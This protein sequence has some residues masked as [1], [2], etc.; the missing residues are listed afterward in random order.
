MPPELNLPEEMWIP[1]RLTLEVLSLFEFDI[2]GST[3]PYSPKNACGRVNDVLL[4]IDERRGLVAAW[5]MDQE[6]AFESN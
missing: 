3:L 1:E 5:S 2:A 4:P 6:F